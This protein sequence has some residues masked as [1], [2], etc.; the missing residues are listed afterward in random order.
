MTTKRTYP[1]IVIKQDPDAPAAYVFAMQA[2]TNGEPLTASQVEAARNAAK[3]VLEIT[4]ADVSATTS[5]LALGALDGNQSGRIV[6]EC[7]QEIEDEIV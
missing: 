1:E 7:K 4:G 3:S 2:K 5:V 6:I